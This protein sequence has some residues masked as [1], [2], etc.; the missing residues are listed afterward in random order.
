MEGGEKEKILN[1][2]K[3]IEKK[4]T[5]IENQL[6]NSSI[7][8]RNETL[9]EIIRDI[10]NRN[11]VL[12]EIEKSKGVHEHTGAREQPSTL[13]NMVNGF[14]SKIQG[15]PTKKIIYLREFLENLP[16]ISNNDKDVIIN[17]LK[18]EKIFDK[19]KEKMLSLITIFK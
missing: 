9:K 17:S 6:S 2:I 8:S 11:S 13:E 1:M 5:D 10:L 14:I 16:L 19:L 3:D 18:D 4:K 15:N 12:K 7:L